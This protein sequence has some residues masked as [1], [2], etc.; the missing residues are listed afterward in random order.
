VKPARKVDGNARGHLRP[1]P[2]LDDPARSSMS[3]SVGDLVVYASH[4][5]GRVESTQPSRR[6]L[7]ETLTLVF[8]SGLKV[9]L[10]LARACDALRPLSTPDE[11]ENVRRTLRADVSPRI[12]PWS[13]RHRT[14]RQTVTTGSIAGLAEVVRDGL[15]REWTL[16]AGNGGRTPAPSEREL[17]LK[18]RGLLAA[19]IAACRGIDAAAADAWIVEQISGEGAQA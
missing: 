15:Q 2:P 8:E 16:A 10:P 18:A 5:V 13:S 19:E 6:D 11:L 14:L 3:L 4:G 7:P 1:A 12:E 17:Y 9:T